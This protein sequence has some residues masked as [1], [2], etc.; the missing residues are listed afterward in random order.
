MSDERWSTIAFSLGIPTRPGKRSDHETNKLA[1]RMSKRKV[2][3]SSQTFDLIASLIH[4]LASV[5]PQLSQENR[6]VY[7]N[8]AVPTLD[9]LK[10]TVHRLPTPKPAISVGYFRDN[11]QLSHDELQNGIITGPAGEPCDLNH[12]SQPVPE[13]FW[14]FFVVEIS[15]KSMAAAR[16]ASAVTAATCNHGLALL[17]EAAREEKG[18]SDTTF[19]RDNRHSKTFSLSVHG[20]AAS[21]SV[22][23]ADASVG[24]LA[25]VI[26]TYMLDNPDSVATLADRIQS[27]FV[28]GRFS[29]LP[30]IMSS[31]DELDRK[32]HG[33]FSG[34]TVLD[35]S[36]DFDPHCLKGLVLEAPRRPDRLKVVLKAGLPSLPSWLKPT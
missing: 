29:R 13:H 2:V 24:E 12:I 4:K 14:P 23:G 25:S 19:L 18:W 6:C 30:S 32:V 9:S 5:H 28:W 26:G 27:I 21:L 3:S 34:V 8:D 17:S 22:H 10:N 7:H 11:F 31:L 35:S 1:Q 33:E 36:Y 20:K 15:D 16:D